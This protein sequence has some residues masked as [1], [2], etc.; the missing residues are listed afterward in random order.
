MRDHQESPS[1]LASRLRPAWLVLA[2]AAMLPGC[3]ATAPS[4]GGGNTTVTGAAGGGTAEGNKSKLERCDESLGTLA[5][6]EDQQRPLVLPSCAATSS[7][8]RSR[9]CA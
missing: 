6:E 5:M 8:R 7:A 9:C 3:L 1:S 4:M 2:V